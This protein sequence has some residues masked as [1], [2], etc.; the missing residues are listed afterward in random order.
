ME[1]QERYYIHHPQKFGTQITFQTQRQ[2]CEE[3][4][5]DEETARAWASK[6][7]TDMILKM[8]REDGRNAELAL[9]I[10][11]RED[12]D[13]SAMPDVS[14]EVENR[15]IKLTAQTLVKTYHRVPAP[16]QNGLHP[17]AT[18]WQKIKNCWRYLRGK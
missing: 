11:K 2:E 18:L 15:V 16:N 14:P 3:R 13:F 9:I 17:A 12:E 4:S 1:R 8:M 5:Q 10:Q 7:I 6:L